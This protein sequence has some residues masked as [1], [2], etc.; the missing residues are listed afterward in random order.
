M[1]PERWQEVKEILAAAL[2]QPAAERNAYLDQA[3]AEPEVR[4]EVDLHGGM[5]A[6]RSEIVVTGRE[7]DL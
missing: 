1:T 2:E 3:C 6:L 7:W 4:R 5:G